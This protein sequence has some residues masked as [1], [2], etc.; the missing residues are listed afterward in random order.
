MDPRT[1]LFVDDER[2]ILNS[3]ERL[4]RKEYYRLLLTE[5]GK[6][7]LDILER[8][9]VHVI[10]ADINM[11]EMDG[12]EL[13]QQVMERYPDIIRV[14][15]SSSSDKHTILNAINTG[16]IYRYIVK[17]WDNNELNLTVLQAIEL[18]NLQQER[19]DLLKKL[20]ESD[21]WQNGKAKKDL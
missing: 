14:I 15:L 3:L 1:V 19:R 2:D 9:D 10:V 13:L 20:E 11:P 12:F 7:S 18:F 17:P 5:S 21:F 16:N 4:L 6:E 8:E